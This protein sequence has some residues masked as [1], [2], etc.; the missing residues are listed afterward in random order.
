MPKNKK[1]KSTVVQCYFNGAS[2][3]DRFM[4]KELKM[5]IDTFKSRI[6]KIEKA[7]ANE[8]VLNSTVKDK[9]TAEKYDALIQKY[10]AQLNK[11]KINHYNKYMPLFSYNKQL[12]NLFNE[13]KP[14]D[15]NNMS[16]LMDGCSR[17]YKENLFNE[18]LAVVTDNNKL[19]WETDFSSR[20]AIKRF[21]D[22]LLKNDF[23][24]MEYYKACY[25]QKKP[26]QTVTYQQLFNAPL[27]PKYEANDSHLEKLTTRASAWAK[28]VRNSDSKLHRNSAEYENM[29]SAVLALDEY[30]QKGNS[31]PT[32]IGKY[33]EEIQAASMT[34]VKA[35]GVGNQS[36]TM[37]K[38]RM[39]F[40]LTF[41]EGSVE[42]MDIYASKDRIAEVKQFEKD[43]FGRVM[44]NEQGVLKY[45][46]GIIKYQE[47]RD[48]D[49][50]TI[51]NIFDNDYEEDMSFD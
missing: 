38:Q 36:S 21:S 41:C 40:A 33:L 49:K 26:V 43:N 44:S 14:I 8:K 13:N 37:G 2:H 51:D 3:M 10:N 30:C 20:S 11:Y 48:L 6:E 50:F 42:F 1:T 25:A 39:N 23:N 28:A 5:D 47:E 29:K 45:G 46:N 19:K 27:P 7:R 15:K 35:K 22:M 9:K 4:K 18:N 31:D 34:Y 16:L 24:K 12:F 17:A 32:E